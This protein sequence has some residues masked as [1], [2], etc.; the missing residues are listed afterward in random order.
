MI[1]L[2]AFPK[3]WIENISSRQMAL[4][5]WIET[6]AQLGADGL[7]LYSLFLRSYESEYLTSIRRRV[8]SL[9]MTIPMMCYSPDFTHPD[10]EFRMREVEKQKEIIRVTASLGGSFCRTLSGQKRPEVGIAEGSD[11]VVECIEACL[12]EA[13]R[14]GI[15]LVIENHYKDGFWTHAEFAQKKEVLLPI[16][17]RIDSPWF[18]VQ[19]DPSNALVAGD[20]AVALLK[21]LVSKVKTMHASDRYLVHGAKLEDV[22]KS[23][24]TIG[25]PDKLVHGVTGDGQNDFDAIFQILAENGFNGWISIEDGMNGMDEMRR[26]IEFLKSMRLKYFG[27]V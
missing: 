21:V 4:E 10:R 15:T 13:E 11:Y 19:F 8:E 5:D 6:S 14:S 24:G 25:Y 2:A 22:M 17:E 23:D 27:K 16:I 18:G 7:E 12:P 9:G 26:S 20:D 1:S 3:C